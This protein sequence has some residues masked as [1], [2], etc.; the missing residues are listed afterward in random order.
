MHRKSAIGVVTAALLTG[1]SVA[2]AAVPAS[3]TTTQPAAVHLRLTPSSAQLAG[4]M[5][6]ATPGTDL[7][8]HVRDHEDDHR[9]R[10]DRPAGQPGLPARPSRVGDLRWAPR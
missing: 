4:C 9:P 8:R 2:A 3:G 10:P 7:R 1:G 5:P 6:H